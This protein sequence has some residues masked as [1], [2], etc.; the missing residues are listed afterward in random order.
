V[1][2]GRLY[3]T[4]DLAR[5]LPD[6]T[7]E[8]LGRVD[9]QVKIRGHRI[10]LGEV[11]ATLRRHTQ[12]ADAAVVAHADATGEPEL[13]AYVVGG[14][15]SP[16]VADL[17]EWLALH[18]PE[19][20]IPTLYLE[21][22]Q[23]PVT[24]SGKL[25]RRALPAPGRSCGMQE[26]DY[27]APRGAV[28]ATLAEVWAGVLGRD[29][30]G[31][32]DN[33]FSLGGHSLKAAHLLGRVHEIYGIELSLRV[34]FEYPTVA[35]LARHLAEVSSRPQEHEADGLNAVDPS[36]DL[37]DLERPSDEETT[38]LLGHYRSGHDDVANA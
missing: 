1:P 33:F 7:L 31:V 14:P 6:G 29:R 35:G 8:C 37:T 11:E 17:R 30:V 32:H 34:L 36:A 16:G 15:K 19:Y 38:S 25:D 24:P 4:G 5:W 9:H 21:L 18:L 10:E 22:D 13:V 2:G 3:R 28:E 23:L 26:P 12:V 27:V 20:M